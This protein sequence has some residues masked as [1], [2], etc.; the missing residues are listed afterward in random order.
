MMTRRNFLVV[1][2]GAALAAASR[3]LSAQADP[4]R[5]MPKIDSHV[6]FVDPTR[7][8]GVPWPPKT[9]NIYRPHLPPKF[10]AMVAPWNVV[11]EIVIEA[12][13]W[14]EDN[15]WILD[16]ARDNTDIVGFIGHLNPGEPEFAAHLRRFAANPI[17]RGIRLWRK[18]LPGAARPAYARDLDLLAERGL[19][20]DVVDAEPVLKELAQLARRH[21]GLRVVID[22]LPSTEWDGHPEAMRAGLADLAACPNVYAKVSMVVRLRHRRNVADPTFYQPGLDVLWNLFGNKRVLYGSNWPASARTANYDEI[23]QA[24]GQYVARLSRRDAEDFYWR[25]SIAAYG[26]LPRGAAAALRP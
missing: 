13:P 11:G 23:F 19:T 14:L 12:S 22:H 6:H 5:S 26:W 16:L 17:Y 8:Q 10:R 4:Y 24:I 9:D 1:S 25:N 21:P 18:E 3:G 2:S 15:Q 20:I 7:P